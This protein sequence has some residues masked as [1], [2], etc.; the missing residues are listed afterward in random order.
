M[1][2]VNFS[3]YSQSKAGAGTRGPADLD[4]QDEK[5]GFWP[6]EKCVKAYTTYLDSKSQ[7]IDEQQTA[8]RYRHGAQ[9][10]SDQIKTFNDRRQ[11]VVT[12]N[13]IGPKIDGIVGTVERLK[14]DPKAFP[15]SPEHQQGADLAT[16]VLRYLMDNN[17]WNAV[18]PI[19]TESMLLLGTK[20]LETVKVAER[21]VFVIVQG[22]SLP[23]V[24][25]LVRQSDS[26]LT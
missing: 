18:T 4:P 16:A 26:S 12:Y 14:Q 10:N 22:V 13:K 19:V 9:W 25:A 7:E 2:V 8:R 21:S 24:S 20:S 23:L 1:A 3:G 17:N 15:R 5:D 6:L 11:P